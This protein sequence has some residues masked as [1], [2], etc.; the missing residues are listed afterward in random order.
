MS[1]DWE[2]IGPVRS[3]SYKGRLAELWFD[4]KNWNL[5]IQTLTRIVPDERWDA[6]ISWPKRISP[7]IKDAVLKAEEILSAEWELI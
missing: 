1:L 5:A 2:K 6:S 7:V 4:A 3:C